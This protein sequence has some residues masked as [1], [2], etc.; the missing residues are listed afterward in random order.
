MSGNEFFNEYKRGFQGK[1]EECK[2]KIDELKGDNLTH[3]EKQKL[4]TDLDFE[5]DEVNNFLK[6]MQF[7]GNLDGPSKAA[8]RRCK[9][10]FRALKKKKKLA[11]DAVKREILTD[12]KISQQEKEIFGNEMAE[13]GVNTLQS[14]LSIL[15]NALQEADEIKEELDSQ[16]KRIKD[17]V[18]KVT[19][20]TD[21][22]SM[23]NKYVSMMQN[24]DMKVRCYITLMWLAM[25]VIIGSTAFYKYGKNEDDPPPQNVIIQQVADP[26]TAPSSGSSG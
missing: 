16:G 9:N 8:M 4:I 21:A 7:S 2:R 14:G 11:E 26:T 3:G 22:L 24:R 18:N 13:E 10:D 15:D 20:M 25:I 17:N 19:G 6:K 12:E 23:A 5:M 1:Y